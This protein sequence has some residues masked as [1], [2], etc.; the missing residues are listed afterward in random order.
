MGGPKISVNWQGDESAKQNGDDWYE[1]YIVEIASSTP[2]ELHDIFT[3]DYFKAEVLPTTLIEGAKYR[4]YK[5]RFHEWW[6]FWSVRQDYRSSGTTA[7]EPIVQVWLDAGLPPQRIFDGVKANV[8]TYGPVKGE[9]VL[10]MALGYDL[11]E[12]LDCR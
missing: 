2:D 11:S 12:K 6:Q 1:N 10:K 9:G 7:I 4:H 8:E 5:I 3:G